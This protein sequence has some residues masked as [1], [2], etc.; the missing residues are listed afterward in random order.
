[1]KKFAEDNKEC[2]SDKNVG[3][4]LCCKEEGEKGGYSYATIYNYF[5]D[6]NT[7]LTYSVFDFF[8]DCYKYMMS[9]KKNAENPK[10]LIV[11]YACAYFKYFAQN[12]DM[13]QLIFLEDFG[14]TP[15]KLMIN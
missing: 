13:F 6:L 14:N 3:L 9:F 15:E 4:F 7:L 10:D 1:V 5:N 2:L 11:T 12:P 8:E